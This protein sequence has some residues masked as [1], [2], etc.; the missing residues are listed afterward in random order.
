MTSRAARILVL[1][2]ALQTLSPGATA[3]A[4]DESSF[5]RVWSHAT[6]Y[7]NRDSGFVQKFALSGRLQAEAAW[8]DAGEGDFDDATWRR[9]RFGFLSQFVHDWRLNVEADLDLNESRRDW[10]RGLTDAY[11]AW[12][13]DEST[14]V[15][16]L[17]QSAGFTLDGATSSKKLLTLQRNNLTHKEVRRQVGPRSIRRL[18]VPITASSAPDFV[19][20][21][22]GIDKGSVILHS[23]SLQ[24]YQSGWHHY[25]RLVIKPDLAY[26]SH[27][28]TP[29]GPKLSG[30]GAAG[31]YAWASGARYVVLDVGRDRARHMTDFLN[32]FH[33]H[34]T[35]QGRA[36]DYHVDINNYR[37]VKGDQAGDCAA[38]C[39]WWLPNL[40]T[41]PGKNLM[42]SLG[43]K[44]TRGPQEIPSI[45]MHAAKNKRCCV[46]GVAVPDLDSFNRLTEQQLFG[47]EPTRGGAA[48]AVR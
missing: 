16:I 11:V 7:E 26:A 13:P 2:L 35:A 14:E 27:Y 15:K 39:M 4:A 9:F 45:A 48:G 30:E 41:A 25:Q 20:A 21:M 31:A 5:D 8:F 37:Q 44:R 24:R 3:Q 42:K 33:G 10:Y 34:S 19:R 43:V 12:R 17:K 22:A 28:D 32:R 1:S 18:F 23:R 38:E 29:K 47:N 46:V 36:Y 40:E 6:L